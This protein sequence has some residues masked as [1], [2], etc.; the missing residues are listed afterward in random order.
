LG[1]QDKNATCRL[2]IAYSEVV[3]DLQNV[4]GWE[5]LYE[6]SHTAFFL[7]SLNCAYLDR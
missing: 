7:S 6:P 5:L 2:R 3:R 1:G 4:S